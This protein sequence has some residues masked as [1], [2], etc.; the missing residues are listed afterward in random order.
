MSVVNADRAATIDRGRDVAL[1]VNDL[2]VSYGSGRNAL[3]AVDGVTVE[4]ERGKTLGVIGESGSGK[5]TLAMSIAGLV[6]A[7]SG[8]IELSTGGSELQPA[9]KSIGRDGFVQVIF[10]DPL[11][12]L[13]PSIPIWKSVVEPLVPSKLRIPTKLKTRAVELLERVGLSADLADRRPAQLSGGQRQRV[14]IARALA[15][16]APIIMCDEPVSALDISLQAGV[17]RLLDELRKD[18]GLTYLFISHDMSSIARLADQVGVMYLG[19]LVEIGPV[20]S[21]LR[22]PM[23][24]YTS[25]LISAI[26]VVTLEKR[27][28]KRMLLPGEIPDGRNPPSGCR[29]R[30]RC[31]FAQPLCAQKAPPMQLA[32]EDSSHQTAC[33]YWREIRDG[34][35]QPRSA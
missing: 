7:A 13:S 18:D 20:K 26:P 28:D 22:R 27:T 32:D 3:R 1:R 8:T 14:T 17:L 11:L 23:H 10:Q 6:R 25:A 5:S 21:I 35:L 2:V 9:A 29:F 24:P 31:P 19:Q 30:T 33:H 12:A 16:K 15:S 4:I 34:E